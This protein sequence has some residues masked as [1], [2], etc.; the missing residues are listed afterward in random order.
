MKWEKGF[1]IKRMRQVHLETG[2]IV[3]IDLK[4]FSMEIEF[5]GTH[6]EQ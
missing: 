5:F 3:K 4:N 6:D 2:T 1:N